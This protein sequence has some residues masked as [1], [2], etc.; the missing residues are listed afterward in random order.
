MIY[1][2]IK[3]GEKSLPKEKVLAGFL[4]SEIFVISAVFVVFRRF[5]HTSYMTEKSGQDR[6]YEDGQ[7]MRALDKCAGDKS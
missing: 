3:G 4:V 7:R 5:L 6:Y 1:S 2:S